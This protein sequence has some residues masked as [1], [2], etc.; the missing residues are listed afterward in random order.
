MWGKGSVFRV[1]GGGSEAG[2]FVTPAVGEGGEAEAAAEEFDEVG[3]VGDQAVAGDFADG[4]GGGDELELGAVEALVDD[5]AVGGGAE[6]ALA[7]VLEGGGAHLALGGEGGDAGGGED[8]GVHDVGE[9][10]LA[11]AEGLAHG[12]A[13]AAAGLGLEELEEFA[14][15][16]PAEFGALPVEA[17]G[18]EAVQGAE[19]AL[20]QGP[21]GVGVDVGGVPAGGAEVVGG[22]DLGGGD[23][24]V[25]EVA[26][27]VEEEGLAEGEVVSG[28]VV[29]DVV[30]AGVQ[31]EE[32]AAADGDVAVAEVD[33]FGALF[34][35]AD[36]VAFVVDGLDA[37]VGVDL[38]AG[39]MGG[40]GGVHGWGGCFGVENGRIGEFYSIKG[41]PR[42]FWCNGLVCRLDG[43]GGW[44]IFG[45]GGGYR[46]LMWRI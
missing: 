27:A 15:F 33:Q 35:V 9:G 43:A 5:P 7:V 14:D 32:F 19:V 20:D 29:F 36:D 40:G 8:V 39:D 30:G 34:D 25:A 2:F 28:G 22:G 4:V 23:E 45:A 42:L 37:G 31:V 13:D 16:E 17:G 44:Y 46:G 10:A 26:G 24:V 3:G 41:R 18:Q 6:G 21:G 12:A 38:V 11:L 1:S